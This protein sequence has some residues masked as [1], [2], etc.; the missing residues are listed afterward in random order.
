MNVK[1]IKSRDVFVIEN[2]NGGWGPSDSSNMKS[3]QVLFNFYI[4]KV[5]GGYLLISQSLDK[6][7]Y[8]DSLHL[9]VDEALEVAKENY[10]ICPNEW[11]SSI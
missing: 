6:S 10:A 4:D 11:E 2:P 7:K 9:T 8:D 5:E 3:Q 1:S